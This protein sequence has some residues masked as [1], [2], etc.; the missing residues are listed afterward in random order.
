MRLRAEFELHLPES[1][2]TEWD[3]EVVWGPDIVDSAAPP[4]GTVIASYST[5]AGTW[6]TGTATGDGYLMRFAD[7]GE[8]VISAQ[9]DRVEVRR[10]WAGEAHI[11]PVLMAGT[12]GAFLLTLRGATVLHASAVAI[13]G[14][15]LAFIGNSGRGKSTMATVMCL[16]GADLVTDD[17]LT[18]DVGPPVTCRGGA[19]EL[20]LRAGA[21]PLAD[22]SAASRRTTEDDRLALSSARAVDAPLPLGAIVVPSPSRDVEQIQIELISPGDAVGAILAFPRIHG[23]SDPGVLARDFATIGKV[24]NA[25]PLYHAIIPWGPPFDPHVA[26]SLADLVR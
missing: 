12:V 17:V 6:Y 3:V 9:L 14:G 15:A 19:S 23:W 4:P 10:D 16:A 25:V 22:Q 5:K 1:D 24:V 11:L 20:R 18:I 7:C 26:R 21:A 8:F 2:D 13:D